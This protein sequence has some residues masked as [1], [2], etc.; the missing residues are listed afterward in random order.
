[1]ADH[2]K[3]FD[4]DSPFDVNLLESIVVAASSPKGQ[5]VEM[6]N[7]A[8]N[9]LTRFREDPRSW[10]QVPTILENAQ[11]HQTKR[12]ALAVMESLVNYRWNSLPLEQQ[13]NIREY[14]ISYVTRLSETQDVLQ[15]SKL[16]LDKADGVI[17]GIARQDWPHRWPEFVPDIVEASKSSES[18]CENNLK[19]LTMLSEDIFDFSED[20][21]T[22]AKISKLKASL[23]KDFYPIYSLCEY[24]LSSSKNAS[25]L[26]TALEALHRFLSW[27]P[28]GYIF[29]TEL[30]MVLLTTFLPEE[31]F[32]GTTLGC[33]TEIAQITVDEA[34]NQE[35]QVMFGMF[36][37]QL[38]QILPPDLDMS[39]AYS[40]GTQ[41]ERKF[42]HL[43]ALFLTSLFKTHLLDI[44]SD[45]LASPILTAHQYLL[46]FCNIRDKD[47]F[48]TILEYWTYLSAGLYNEAV[49]TPGNVALPTHRRQF[50]SDILKQ[51]RVT[52]ISNMAKPEEYLIVEDENGNLI[53]EQM[54][55]TEQLDLYKVMKETLVYLANL[56]MQDMQNTMMTMLQT[57]VDNAQNF[58][59]RNC[60]TLCWAIGSISGV[61]SEEQEKGF[62]V[63][64]VRT[65][66]TMCN[67]TRVKDHRAVIAGN[68]MYV[69]GQYPRFLKAYWTFLKTVVLKLF[70]WMSETHPG[71]QDMAC[72]TFL[73][74]ARRTKSRFVVTQSKEERPFVEDIIANVAQLVAD[75][76]DSQVYTFYSAVGELISAADANSRMD[77]T[78]RLMYLPNASWS[79]IMA[80]AAQDVNSLRQLELIRTI[81]HLIRTNTAACQRIGHYFIGQIGTIYLDMLN[82]YKVYS[83]DITASVQQQGPRYL[84]T[85]DAKAKRTVK[86][87]ILNLLQAFIGV[88]NRPESVVEEL[89]PPLLTPVLDDYNLGIPEARDPEVLGLV[90]ALVRKCHNL[91]AADIPRIFD[92]VFSVTMQ[93]IEDDFAN[94]PDHRVQ[95]FGFLR[96][97]NQFCFSALLDMSPD[98]FKL[99][100]D[101][102]VWAFRHTM[103]GVAKTGLQL[104]VEMLDNVEKAGVADPF[105]SS[106]FLLLLNE[107]LVVLTNGFHKS[108]M[109]HQATV[110]SK[111]FS[112]VQN[113]VITVPLWDPNTQSAANN[114]D[115]IGEYTCNLVGDAFPNLSQTVVTNFVQGLFQLCDDSVNFKKHIQDFLVQVMEVSDPDQDDNMEL[116]RE[117]LAAEL[118]LKIDED[119]TT[120]L[121]IPGMVAP[122]DPR[123]PENAVPDDQRPF[124]MDD[125]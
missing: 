39:Q 1:M 64:V 117:D 65:L 67:N 34:H 87:A 82:V 62:L 101:S 86:A 47:M 36:M 97:V 102:I 95:F 96:T 84:N 28:E 3:L 35:F 79:A 120:K 52:L 17:V 37:E 19:I 8:N 12:F 69:V 80:Q 118:K 94:F 50:Y 55:N 10:V 24:V 109:P 60:S 53:R 11:H 76:Q 68:I 88:T 26:K 58:S 38:I 100:V 56:D 83:E 114:V 51:V 61:Q 104:L 9:I 92:S 13:V 14:I 115:F 15:E 89:L 91:I 93:M 49:I 54:K 2:E 75:L 43:V 5:S 107:L 112:A 110:L 121:A 20:K 21:M 4:F 31:Q 125:E 72:D 81:A 71:V 105:Y 124:T 74:I 40:N 63:N 42:V 73:K 59:K 66:I 111:M 23:V 116:F 106:W 85:T 90:S 18:A 98:N 122:D 77:L 78:A 25:L 29:G 46:G 16:I 119:T 27:I 103:R 48:R 70:E 44:E 33:L 30:V 7:L 45:D 123:R 57:Q 32:R 6:F 22:R 113:G 108:E 41:E 99:V